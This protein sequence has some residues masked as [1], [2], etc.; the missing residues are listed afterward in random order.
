HA[1]RP[2]LFSVAAPGVDRPDAAADQ[3]AHDTLTALFPAQKSG[4]DQM[5][6]SELAAIRDALLLALGI[7][8]G[9]E[10]AGEHLVEP[11][12]L[13]R[14]EGGQ[15]VV[16]GLVGGGVRPCEGWRRHREQV[17]P[18]RVRDR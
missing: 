15:R 12:L 17:R 6:A 3:A 9:R 14:V 5:L 10:L 2:Y 7:G 18:G 13:R 8:D 4:L 16:R 1:A 11:A